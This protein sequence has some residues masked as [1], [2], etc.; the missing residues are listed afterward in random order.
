[1][2]KLLTSSNCIN[3][4]IGVSISYYQIKINKNTGN[5]DIPPPAVYTFKGILMQEYDF[6]SF[7]SVTA[8]LKSTSPDSFDW[9][10]TLQN[11][12]AKARAFLLPQPH[13]TV[14]R[15][16]L[17][18]PR[19]PAAGQQQQPTYKQNNALVLRAQTG[20]QCPWLTHSFPNLTPISGPTLFPNASHTFSVQTYQHIYLRTYQHIYLL[21]TLLKHSWYLSVE[22]LFLY[23]RSSRANPQDCSMLFFFTSQ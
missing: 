15:M 19:H 22:D 18:V 10:K 21:T 9:N 2:F 5:H 23:Q 20:G 13:F 1:M 11:P 7:P 16:E 3:V 14:A 8:M 17:A 6:L 12:S 4:F